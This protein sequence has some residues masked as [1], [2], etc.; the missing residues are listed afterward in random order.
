MIRSTWLTAAIALPAL[1][2]ASCGG[3]S[4]SQPVRSTT[5]VRTAK[6]VKTRVAVASSV[7]RPA[8]P[9]TPPTA[10]I[11]TLPGVEGVIGATTTQLTREFGTP[12]LDVWEGDARK[13]QFSGTPCVLDV[14]LYP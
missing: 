11:Q 1:L 4:T 12:R 14:Y 10:R 3:G 6:P 5:P 7:R 8:P 9:I 13:L 2:L